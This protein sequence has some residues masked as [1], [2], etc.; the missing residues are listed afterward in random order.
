MNSIKILT[1]TIATLFLLFSTIGLYGQ[2]DTTERHKS[3][4]WKHV[5]FGGGFGLGIGSGFTDVTLAP[6]GIYNLNRYVSIGAGLQGSLIS[7]K[8]LYS[9]AIYGVNVLTLFNPAE[10]V[11]ISLEVEQVRVNNTFRNTTKGTLKD[12]FWNTGLFVGAGYRM[13]NVT[14]GMRYNLLF[15]KDKNVYSDALMPFIRIYF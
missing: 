2:M 14:I 11:Q 4:F 5:Q 10:E 15:N 12:N 7:Q 9:S 6:S 1:N 3:D 13:E 8:D